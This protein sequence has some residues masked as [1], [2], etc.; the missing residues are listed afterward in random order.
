MVYASSVEYI[1]EF[2][3][4]LLREMF[5][6]I[7]CWRNDFLVINS[8]GCCH[9]VHSK[10]TKFCQKRNV[11]RGSAAETRRAFRGSDEQYNA[12]AMHEELLITAANADHPRRPPTRFRL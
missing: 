10:F 3:W 9:L 7:V 8:V 12:L 11:A 1:F 6:V 2:C 4:R 5:T